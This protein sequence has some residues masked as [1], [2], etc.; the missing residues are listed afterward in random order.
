VAKDVLAEVHTGRYGLL[1]DTDR[2][3]LFED[4]EHV[5][6]A[7]DE[8]AVLYFLAQGYLECRPIRDTV[9]CLHGAIRRPV[10]PLRL[11]RTGRTMLDRWS[12]YTPLG[13]NPC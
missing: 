1:D 4:D 10:L 9:T 6:V 13:G 2:V 12:A 8:D 7:L 11:T 3:V 5:R